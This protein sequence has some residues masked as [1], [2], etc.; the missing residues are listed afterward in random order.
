MFINDHCFKILNAVA[1]RAGG[2]NQRYPCVAKSTLPKDTSTLQNIVFTAVKLMFFIWHLFALWAL[3]GCPF[4]PFWVSRG[5]LWDLPGH[6]KALLGGP[7]RH[8]N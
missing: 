5:G 6:P 8:P 7:W 1:Q 3:P 4:A 2:F